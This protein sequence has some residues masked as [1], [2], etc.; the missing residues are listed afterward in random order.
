[1]IRCAYCGLKGLGI[2]HINDF[3]GTK[4][5]GSCSDCD[6]FLKILDA[7]YETIEEE[8]SSK[9][10][11]DFIS[12]PEIR[13]LVDF[14]FI[15]QNNTH[16][17]AYNK[18]VSMLLEYSLENKRK[19][20]E[21]E[22]TRKI[23]SSKSFGEIFTPFIFLELVTVQYDTE[24]TYDRVVLINDKFFKF[25]KA[26][27]VDADPSQS[28]LPDQLQKRTALCLLGYLLLGL[29]KIHADTNPD[30]FPS[31]F[32]LRSLWSTFSYIWPTAW[33]NEVYFNEDDFETHVKRR[34]VTSASVGKILQA[35]RQLNPNQIN[36]LFEAIDTSGNQRK[37]LF[38]KEFLNTVSMIRDR[39]DRDRLERDRQ[40]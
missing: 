21:I 38:N 37:Y 13:M 3:Q 17:A 16:L 2:E 33:S 31:S 30:S 34:G 36:T 29:M 8:I 5:F 11:I 27:L 18:T 23:S 25:S 6:T 24:Q 19:I 32:R 12:M 35:F 15:S 14:G 7:V 40:N 9:E 10:I 1:M 26:I 22:I 4:D 20:K 28:K 39:S